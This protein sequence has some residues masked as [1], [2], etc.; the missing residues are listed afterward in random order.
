MPEHIY[1]HFYIYT[2]KE[3]TNAL[4]LKE[5]QLPN[6]VLVALLHHAFVSMPRGI[7]Q[8]S[9]RGAVSC[10]YRAGWVATY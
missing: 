6:P 3:I 10:G 2:L 9:Y 4:L 1:I 5:Q 7:F 8:F